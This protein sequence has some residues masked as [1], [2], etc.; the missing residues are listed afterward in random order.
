MTIKDLSP[1]GAPKGTLLPYLAI[2]VTII[3]WGFSYISTKILLTSL[4][5]FQLAAGRF[6]LASLFLLFVGCIS[7]RICMIPLKKWPQLAGASLLGIVIYFICENF[8]LSL[9]TAGMGS[10][11]IATIPVLNVIISSIFYQS[12]P[13][14]VVW[15]GVLLSTLGVFLIIRAGSDFSFMSLWGNLLILGAA[16]SWVGYTLINQ[17]L[18]AEYDL[19]SL[20]IYQVFLGAPILMLLALIEGKPLPHLSWPLLL[21]LGFLAFFCSALAYIFYSYALRS[22]GATVV[23]TFINFIP[24]CGVLGGIFFLGESFQAYQVLGGVI[25]LTGVILAGRNGKV[26]DSPTQKAPTVIREVN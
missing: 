6:F 25:I 23:T 16:L 1:T 10:L 22:L 19:F 9:T 12:R 11:I 5:P 14:P 21:H 8:G 18:A 7:G 17:R 3:F 15:I 13:S 24:V 4:T 20:N 2:S 26:T